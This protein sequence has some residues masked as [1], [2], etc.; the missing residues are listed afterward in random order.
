MTRSARDEALVYVAAHNVMTL[1]TDGPEGLWAA[2]LFYVS[3]G[4]TFW[5]LSAPTTRHSRNIA[6]RPAVAGT[7]QE[8]YDDW[9][10]IRG[11]QF[12]GVASRIDGRARRDAIARYRE[13]FPVIGGAAGASLEIARALG[14]VDWY[15]VETD[16]VFFID[17]SLGLGHRDE[18]DPGPG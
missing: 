17:N 6:A 18:I 14:K 11:V 13:K 12:E 3:E 9:R 5:F 7:I 2:A 4:F 1:A 10:D 8:D 15:V 16:R